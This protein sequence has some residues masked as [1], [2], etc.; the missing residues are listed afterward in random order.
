[1][2]LKVGTLCLMT[3]VAVLY[4]FHARRNAP[5]RALAWT[6]LVLSLI[7]LVPFGFV[8]ISEAMSLGSMLCR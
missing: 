3:P 8:M 7:V 1:L 2:V 6:G 4:G 5:E